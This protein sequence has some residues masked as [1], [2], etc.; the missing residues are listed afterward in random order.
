MLANLG[1]LEFKV[2]FKLGGAHDTGNRDAIFFEDEILLVS[3]DTPDELAQIH[4]RFRY[5]KT[6]HHGIHFD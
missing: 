6:M 1:V 5:W 2:V 3:I 4:T